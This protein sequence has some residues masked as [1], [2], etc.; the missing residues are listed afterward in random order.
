MPTEPTTDVLSEAEIAELRE[1]EGKMTPGPWAWFSYGE[2]CYGW[3]ICTA[4]PALER[5]D[6]LEEYPAL[7]GEI[8]PSPRGVAPGELRELQNELD[9][10]YA[11]PIDD[12]CDSECQ[13]GGADI[14]G[15]ALLR[16]RIV[17]LLDSHEALRVEVQTLNKA[18]SAVNPRLYREVFGDDDPQRLAQAENY[19][20]RCVE[21][22]RQELEAEPDLALLPLIQLANKEIGAARTLRAELVEN[23]G[24]IRVLRRR[25]AERQVAVAD[26]AGLI[27]RL[28]ERVRV[29]EEA[30]R[31][32][33]DHASSAI[34]EDEDA[35][36]LC[37]SLDE[38]RRA[39][40][41]ALAPREGEAAGREGCDEGGDRR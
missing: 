14:P 8:I 2:K 12:I 25:V 19:I 3:A 10:E 22:L 34:R 41:E 7:C 29:L 24:V 15:I 26:E 27:G 30:L 36:S 31:A 11:M 5:H 21:L 32:I 40:E 38:V 9:V 39:A 17:A 16:N 4:T 1:A 20:S 28:R 23:E 18:N 6:G 33:C 35:G 13:S 37:G